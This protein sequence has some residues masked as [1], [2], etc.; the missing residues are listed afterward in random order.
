MEFAHS[1]DRKIFEKIIEREREKDMPSWDG[2]SKGLIL[3]E[4][5]HLPTR[6]ERFD[7]NRIVVIHKKT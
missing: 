1:F 6:G 4:S 7:L 3:Y 5:T 2:N